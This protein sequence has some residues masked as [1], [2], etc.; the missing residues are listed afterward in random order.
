MQ[1][2]FHEVQLKAQLILQGVSVV[3]FQFHEVQLKACALFNT[4]SV[5]L[6]FNSMKYN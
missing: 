5:A 2:Q 1:F 6:C 4:F 3:T